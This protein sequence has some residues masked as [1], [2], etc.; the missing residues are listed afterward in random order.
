VTKLSKIQKALRSADEATAD[1]ASDQY[2]AA[3]DAELLALYRSHFPANW[4][5]T[6]RDAVLSLREAVELMIAKY[7]VDAAWPTREQRDAQARLDRDVES[8]AH[9]ELLLT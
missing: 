8:L 9:P 1:R 4:F 2:E 5:E 6:N 7:G 3:C